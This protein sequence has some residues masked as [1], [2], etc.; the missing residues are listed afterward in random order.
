MHQHDDA[1]FI[2]RHTNELRLLLRSTHTR[3]NNH[4]G[5]RL[6]LP[7]GMFDNQRSTLGGRAHML[8]GSARS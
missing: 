6:E 3:R 1:M 2:A 5:K 7:F 4:L 8:R